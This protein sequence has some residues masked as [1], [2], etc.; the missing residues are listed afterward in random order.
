[1]ADVTPDAQ[2]E[3][4]TIE[5]HD[6]VRRWLLLGIAVIVVAILALVVFALVSGL[7][8]RQAPRT[9]TEAR[10]VTLRSA[11]EGAPGSG[12]AQ[13]DYIEALIISGQYGA[14]RDQIDIMKEQLAA[15]EVTYVY[16]AELGLLLE[17]GD[18]DRALEVAEEAYK[19]EI[20]E[21]E[22]WVAEQTAAGRSVD[23]TLL[24][25]ENV[26]AIQVYRA[27]ASGGLGDVELGVEYLSEA[28]ELD[29]GAADLLVLRGQ[30]YLELGDVDAA[31]ADFEQA[32]VFIPDFQP[33][34][35]GLN[36]LDGQ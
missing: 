19:Y 36:S 30:G 6:P 16:V 12:A 9:A 26:I 28:L 35:E 18:F 14:A 3:Y 5:E 32:L 2:Y 23:R 11:A 34:L 13:R 4:E 24:S 17:R 22:A 10:L 31:R 25:Q 33:A 1:M 8:A 7:F 29:P 27:R 21:Q 20:A 15:T